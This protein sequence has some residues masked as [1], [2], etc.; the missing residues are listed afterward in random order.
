VSTVN[1]SKLTSLNTFA[2]LFGKILQTGQSKAIFKKRNVLVIIC[3][4]CCI[5]QMIKH[6]EQFSPEA[7]AIA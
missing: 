1:F 6:W 2:H 5:F 4:V 7:K 3:I